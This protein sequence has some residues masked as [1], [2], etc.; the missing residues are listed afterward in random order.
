MSNVITVKPRVRKR[1][2]MQYTGTP[3]NLKEVQEF[4]GAEVMERNHLMARLLLPGKTEVLTVYRKDWILES[5]G[6][7][8]KFFAQNDV[9]FQKTFKVAA[10]G[11]D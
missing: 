11:D 4:T 3:E 1:R 9:V 7:G 5:H 6:V 10:R 8:P 2:A